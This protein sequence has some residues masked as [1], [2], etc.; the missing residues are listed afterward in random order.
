MRKLRGWEGCMKSS[1][2][3]KATMYYQLKFF[4]SFCV[5]EECREKAYL[6]G[7]SGL[8][9]ERGPRIRAAM[10]DSPFAPATTDRPMETKARTTRFGNSLLEARKSRG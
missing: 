8:V 5:V 2:R 7:L 1:T 4:E 9:L 10:M 3:V 6:V